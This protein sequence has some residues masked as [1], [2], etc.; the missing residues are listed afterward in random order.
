MGLNSISVTWIVGKVAKMEVTQMTWAYQ[1][2]W[3]FNSCVTNWRCVALS[4]LGINKLVKTEKETMA[5]RMQ[6]NRQNLITSWLT[7]V[8]TNEVYFWLVFLYSP[9]SA[10]S[11]YLLFLLM[12]SLKRV[13]I[14]IDRYKC[15][16]LGANQFTHHRRQSDAERCRVWC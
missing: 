9:S 4:I 5:I 7:C 11:S 6:I 16:C 10:S 15:P 3:H 13:S 12:G 8:Q 14:T 2:W 1:F